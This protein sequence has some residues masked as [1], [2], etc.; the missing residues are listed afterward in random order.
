LMLY[1]ESRGRRSR[2]EKWREAWEVL[3]RVVRRRRGR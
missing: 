3:Q 1:P 2:F